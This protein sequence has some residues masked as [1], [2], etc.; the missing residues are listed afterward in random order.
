MAEKVGK[1]KDKKDEQKKQGKP[2]RNFQLIKAIQGKKQKNNDGEP[3]LYK[4]NV[5]A[6]DVKV[7]RF[8]DENVNSKSTGS[9]MPGQLVMFN[10]FQ[11]KTEEQLKYYDAMPCTIFFGI[12]KT[13]DGPRVIGFNIHYYPPKIR[14]ELMDRIF[15]IFKP[16]YL[17]SWNGELKKEI[18]DF[19][20][21]M[22]IRQLQKA[23][24][25]FGVRQYIPSLMA[26]ITPIPPKYWQKAVFTEGKFKKETR[27][28][29]L[30]YWKN[31]SY[32][33][34]K[35]SKTPNK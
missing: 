31:K 21:Q 13:D 30:N 14:Y 22:L 27:T 2:S 32:G 20:Y 7:R 25:D 26:K 34:E 35:K 19:D 1:S 15:D 17:E 10:Y 3:Q 18:S 8:I 24:L 33:I 9:V 4:A 29:I 12:R 5:Q 11:P 16:F 28:Q 6:R 23:K